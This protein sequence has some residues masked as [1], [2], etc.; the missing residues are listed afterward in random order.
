MLRLCCRYGST[1]AGGDLEIRSRGA[2]DSGEDATHHALRPCAASE[3]S[4]DPYS[5]QNRFVIPQRQNMHRVV[6]EIESQRGKESHW[7]WFIFPT[8]PWVVD[9]QERGSRDN[10]AYA[11]RDLVPKYALTGDEACR[12][13]LTFKAPGSDGAAGGNSC[14][15]RANYLLAVKALLARLEQGSSA[16]EVLGGGNARKLHSS[17]TLFGRVAATDD[18]DPEIARLC[19]RVLVSIKV[20]GVDDQR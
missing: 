19:E 9:G 18:F 5:F 13:Y 8:P 2:K 15:L 14:E 4:A 3:S 12:S 10:R 11:L 6:R 16:A 7:M 20:N 1:E 17:I